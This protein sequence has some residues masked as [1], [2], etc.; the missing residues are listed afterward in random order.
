[1][2]EKIT[3]RKEYRGLGYAPA[4]SVPGLVQTRPIAATRPPQTN[5]L[6]KLAKSLKDFGET[7]ANSQLRKAAR[8]DQ[9]AEQLAKEDFVGLGRETFLGSSMRRGPDALEMTYGRKGDVVVPDRRSQLLQLGM[10]ELITRGVVRAEATPAYYSYL[11]REAA[12]SIVATEYQK[13]LEAEINKAA[14]FD[15]GPDPIDVQARTR[16]F[17]NT[18]YQELEKKY[19]NFAIWAPE[20][21]AAVEE[22]FVQSVR[23]KHLDNRKAYLED[24]FVA[25]MRESFAADSPEQL[26]EQVT[27]SANE[28]DAAGL[29]VQRLTEQAAVS[30]VTF[31]IARGYPEVARMI[32]ERVQEAGF[33]SDS[34]KLLIGAKVSDELERMIENAE[35]DQQ[36]FT[37]MDKQ[38]AREFI[39]RKFAEE[40][41][42]LGQDLSRDQVT[43]LAVKLSNESINTGRKIQGPDG[44]PIDL[45][46]QIKSIDQGNESF[47]PEAIAAIGDDYLANSRVTDRLA[48]YLTNDL[49]RLTSQGTEDSL[50]KARELLEKPG[51]RATIGDNDAANYD[52][53]I[54]SGQQLVQVQNHPTFRQK[55]EQA[56]R[57][58]QQALGIDDPSNE[59]TDRVNSSV[60]QAEKLTKRVLDTS[61]EQFSDWLNQNKNASVDARNVELERIIADV[62]KTE[63]EAFL[64]PEETKNLMEELRK[65]EA[66][67]RAAIEEPNWILGKKGI[68]DLE[69][70][71]KE[72]RTAQETFLNNPKLQNLKPN[73][74]IASRLKNSPTLVASLAQRARKL[75]IVRRNGMAKRS[76]VSKKITD[77]GRVIPGTAG[78]P[79]GLPPTDDKYVPY[80]KDELTALYVEL[81]RSLTL[82][83]LTPQ[84]VIDKNINVVRYNATTNTEAKQRGVG[85]SL[86]SIAKAATPEGEDGK[87]LGVLLNPYEVPMFVS[88]KQLQELMGEKGQPTIGKMLDSLGIKDDEQGTAKK[89]FL[90]AQLGLLRTLSR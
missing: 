38:K 47:T 13:G 16:D 77:G 90:N 82:T 45:E 74:S 25:R 7:F 30:S 49:Q 31:Y 57:D 60:E 10:S 53:L 29:D 61:R 71:R 44:E 66:N 35:R 70:Q 64:A 15:D 33:G 78:D 43:A 87:E 51:T 63:K 18:V 83:G 48:K 62:Y 37:E 34:S 86:E 24:K 5:E 26:I 14:L 76:S 46:L 8:E 22:Q 27:Q 89:A 23:D 80:E 59:D 69:R 52:R 58:V 42:R 54:K 40:V 9:E 41:R 81:R 11:K 17:T 20:E 2:A 50:K 12:R 3:Q 55:A 56:L 19:G 28:G 6:T 65:A 67:R 73:E 85:I 79:Y 68:D 21:V 1:M 36:K 4:I 84:E 75:E 32:A 88:V 39:A 72:L